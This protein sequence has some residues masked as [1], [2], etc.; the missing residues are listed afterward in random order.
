MGRRWGIFHVIHRFCTELKIQLK[1]WIAI[2]MHIQLF[3]Q[4]SN[5]NNKLFIKLIHD[6]ER[7]YWMLFLYEAWGGSEV[8]CAVYLCVAALCPLPPFELCLC[9]KTVG[10]TIRFAF[11]HLQ[12]MCYFSI[13]HPTPTKT[14]SV[15]RKAKLTNIF[16]SQFNRH[17]HF[18]WIFILL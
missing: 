12:K 2:R 5:N 4:E 14:I 15:T 17:Q 7:W 8:W 9:S 10:Q 13:C 18:N 16:Q 1:H 6:M 11:V 3:Q